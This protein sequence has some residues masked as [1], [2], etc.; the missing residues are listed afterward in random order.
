MA[1]RVAVEQSLLAWAVERSGRDHGEI[2]RRVPQL[3]AWERGERQPT[4]RQLEEFAR[5]TRTPVGY[6]LLP[7]PP[8]EQV[9]IPDFRTVGDRGVVRPSADLLDTLAA[10]RSG[11]VPAD[12]AEGADAAVPLGECLDSFF[13]PQGEPGSSLESATA[14]EAPADAV[15]DQVP[16]VEVAIRGLPLVEI[17]RP[18]YQ[19]LSATA[20]SATGSASS[21]PRN[22]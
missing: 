3:E 5:Q 8:E 19:A 12:R 7:D 16:E 1:V 6:L 20:Q 9:P 11:G 14:G 10:L 21:M 4:M 17:L 22:R 18:V 15:L 13:A 2:V